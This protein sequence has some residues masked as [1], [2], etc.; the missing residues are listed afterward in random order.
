MPNLRIARNDTRGIVLASPHFGGLALLAFGLGSAYLVHRFGDPGAGRTFGIAIA[1]FF[2]AIGLLGFLWRD[3]I[4]LDLATR[5]WTRTSGFFLAPSSTSGA[6]ASLAGI[7]IELDWE[8]VGGKRNRRKV[9]EWEVGLVFAPE[10]RPVTFVETR[11]EAA[12]YRAA[13]DMARRLGL[14]ILD[15]TRGRNVRTPASHVDTPLA[16]NVAPPD[17]PAAPPSGLPPGSRVSVG[18]GIGGRTI[19]IA[20]PG[21]TGGVVMLALVGLVFAGIGL[22]VLLILAGVLDL[23]FSGSAIAG[24]IVGAGFTVVGS[25][26]I[27]AAIAGAR[28][29]RWVR[30]EGDRLVFGSTVFGSAKQDASVPKQAIESID[31]VESSET[32][33]ASSRGRNPAIQLRVRSD[34]EIV[35]LGSDLS[36][37]EKAWLRQTLI[38]MAQGRVWR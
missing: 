1:L 29:A 15:R 10:E 5:R 25:F 4:E 13:E 28:R 37:E 24:G 30:E 21:F 33:R 11:E 3:R 32:R 36:D 8:R 31:L 20:P 6:I 26:L 16:A 23:P 19:H 18:E 17:P 35:R 34:D 38:A 12:A 27:W 7:S 2:A 14:D 22:T 9:A